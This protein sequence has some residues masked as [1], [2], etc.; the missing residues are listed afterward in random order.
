LHNIYPKLIL[1]ISV[2]FIWRYES[3]ITDLMK[4]FKKRVRTTHFWS[5]IMH[6]WI[7]G[8][9]DEIR[10]ILVQ[11][12]HY[13]CQLGADNGILRY[14][15][16]LFRWKFLVKFHHQTSYLSHVLSAVNMKSQFDIYFINRKVFLNKTNYTWSKI[17]REFQIF[18]S[19]GKCQVYIHK[20]QLVTCWECL[21][22]FSSKYF[23]PPP[24]PHTN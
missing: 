9:S 4:M 7:S 18:R 5:V 6:I 24:S 8:F 21:I 23:V 16:S 3:I 13:Q 19:I 1:L 10:I 20:T 17:T 12:L 11:W 15:V 14:I 2:F 22:E